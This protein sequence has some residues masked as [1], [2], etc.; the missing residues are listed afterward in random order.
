MIIGAAKY[1]EV[2]EQQKG[3]ARGAFKPGTLA[4][5][6]GYRG[7]MSLYFRAEGFVRIVNALA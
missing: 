3:L 5:E 1:A 4:T 2:R 6:V 7:Y